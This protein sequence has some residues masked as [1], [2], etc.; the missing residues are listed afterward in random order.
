MCIYKRNQR[1]NCAIEIEYAIETSKFASKET[2]GLESGE[3]PLKVT[4][5]DT[6]IGN[7]LFGRKKSETLC[8]IDLDAVLPKS[9]LYDF[10]DALRISLLI[11]T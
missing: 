10:D 7:I 3:I 2:D 9:A 1:K 4:H 5:N 11:A 6:K 8:V